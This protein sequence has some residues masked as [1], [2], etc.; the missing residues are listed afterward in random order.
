MHQFNFFD[1]TKMILT[2][3]GT[4]ITFIDP[5][6]NS[7]TCT[8]HS[9]FTEAAQLGHYRSSTTTIAPTSSREAAAA[10]ARK[11][12][13]EKIRFIIAKVEYCRDVLLNLISRKTATTGTSAASNLGLDPPITT[14]YTDTI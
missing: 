2:N 7:R 10:S 4:V 6:S 9:L 11:R 12:E 8:L 3:H 1:H 14:S 5:N 13:L